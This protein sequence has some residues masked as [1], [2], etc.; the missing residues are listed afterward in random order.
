M[1]MFHGE[2]Y[3]QSTM[4]VQ[5]CLSSIVV[6]FDEVLSRLCRIDCIVFFD[7]IQLHLPVLIGVRIKLMIPCSF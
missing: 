2:E 1:L 4:G 5:I 6:V 3:T 7:P